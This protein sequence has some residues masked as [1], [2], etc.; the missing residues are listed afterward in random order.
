VIVGA[1]F[2]TLRF[3]HVDHKELERLFREAQENDRYENG[4][5]YSGGVGMANGLSITTKAFSNRREAEAWLDDNTIKW[6]EAKAV[7]VRPTEGNPYWLV[8]AVCAS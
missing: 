5:R 8:G 6:E 4:H 2:V 3:D 1:Y 7:S